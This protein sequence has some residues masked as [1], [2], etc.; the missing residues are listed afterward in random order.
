MNTVVL[1]TAML[2]G[3]C[4]PI[5]YNSCYAPPLYVAP[6]RVYEKVYFSED[7]HNRFIVEA[8]W[9]PTGKKFTVPI[10]NGYAPSI[11]FVDLP[12]GNSL[13]ELDYNNRDVYEGG[14]VKYGQL[15]QS[16]VKK[17]KKTPVPLQNE[18]DLRPRPIQAP[19]V[20]EEEFTVMK[21]N[22][23]E[24]KDAVNS[25]REDGVKAFQQQSDQTKMLQDALQTLQDERRKQETKYDERQPERQPMTLQA[26]P[27]RIE[28]PKMKKPSEFGKE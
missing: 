2:A 9:V 23:R 22:I 7:I 17:S 25:I 4:E 5:V 15:P 11:R 24:L 6:S 1:L 13:R 19:S 18:D 20:S 3:Q 16:Q 10:V 12:D 14:I 27:E 28:S 8:V 26:I 21:N